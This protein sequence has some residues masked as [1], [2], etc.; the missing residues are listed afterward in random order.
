MTALK[1][2]KNRYEPWKVLRAGIDDAA[3]LLEL[4]LE[5]KAEGEAADCYDQIAVESDS[6]SYRK[7][8]IANAYESFL[9]LPFGRGIRNKRHDEC[10]GALYG[11]VEAFQNRPG[12]RPD[13]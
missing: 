7:A 9:G 3:T 13:G 8:Q 11:T 4:A 1:T 2:L 10:P 12:A 5:A 6:A